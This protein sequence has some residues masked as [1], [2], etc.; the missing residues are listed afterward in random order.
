MPRKAEESADAREGLAPK[1]SYGGRLGKTGVR[2]VRKIGSNAGRRET[3]LRNLYLLQWSRPGRQA[4]IVREL[5]NGSG[6]SQPTRRHS[7]FRS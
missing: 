1:Y 5:G 6:Q 7:C 3:G 2:A 4:E